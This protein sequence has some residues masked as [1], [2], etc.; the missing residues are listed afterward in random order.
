LEVPCVTQESEEEEEGGVSVSELLPLSGVHPRGND[1]RYVIEI[2]E[3]GGLVEILYNVMKCPG[4]GGKRGWEREREAAREGRK[5]WGSGEM[6]FNRLAN[7][8]L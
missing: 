1:A 7:F 2:S 6:C 3:G 4:I 5:G 8:G